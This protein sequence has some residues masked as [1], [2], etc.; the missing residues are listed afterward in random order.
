MAAPTPQQDGLA[1]PELRD[2]VSM[3]WDKCWCLL[4]LS[5]C[6]SSA[7]ALQMGLTGFLQVAGSYCLDVC[8]DAWS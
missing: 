8:L 4:E 1:S 5:A 7:L 6:V 2:C 3:H